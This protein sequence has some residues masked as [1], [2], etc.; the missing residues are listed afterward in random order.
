MVRYSLMYTQ[1]RLNIQK[2]MNL[3]VLPI[4]RVCV[5]QRRVLTVTLGMWRCHAL[6]AGTG[7][8]SS[9]ATRNPSCHDV[10]VIRVL[11]C[12]EGLSF[13]HLM[14]VW[15]L[16]HQLQ[17]LYSSNQTIVRHHWP[18]VQTLIHTLVE[19]TNHSAT[20]IMSESYGDVRS[21]ICETAYD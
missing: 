8:G 14:M 9:F 11:A 10:R 5:C 3:T 16:F 17:K 19:S 20:R 2:S 6:A 7:T 15:A 4:W 12:F 21:W 13:K 18:R 1:V